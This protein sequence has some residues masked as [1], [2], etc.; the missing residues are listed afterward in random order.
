MAD[1]PTTQPRA[2][3]HH[4]DLRRSLVE[5]A[6]AIIAGQG[7]DALTLRAV[8]ERAGVSRT[9]LYRH[10][11]DKAALLAAVALSGFEMLH[12]DLSAATMNAR[13]EGTDPLG[14]LAQAYVAFG[15]R[16]P[17]HYRTMFGP[18]VADRERYPD[19]ATTG[20]ATF[21]ALVAEVVRGQQSGQLKSG[22]PIRMAQVF[23]STLHGIV[24]LKGDGRFGFLPGDPVGEPS[25]TELAADILITGMSVADSNC[26]CSSN[27]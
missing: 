16:H 17:P 26:S 11:A 12:R 4:G 19:L 8:G 6:A 24:M 10:F 27:P 13:S 3:Y 9:A 20:K 2:S 1:D 18:G 22:D 5:A 21:N 14:A 7:V 23:W 25:L 15:T